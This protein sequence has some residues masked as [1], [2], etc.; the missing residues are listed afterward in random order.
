MMLSSQPIDAASALRVGL[1]N[2]LLPAD[3]LLPRAIEVATAMAAHDPGLIRIVKGVLDRGSRT[4]LGEAMD[5]EAEALLR[6]K[7]EGAMAWT[8]LPVRE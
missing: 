2:E 4:T 6:R 1:I 5:I 7:A 3:R 8:T